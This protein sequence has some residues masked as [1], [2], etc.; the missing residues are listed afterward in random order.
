MNRPRFDAA[1]LGAGR[2]ARGQLPAALFGLSSHGRVLDWQVNALRPYCDQVTFVGGYRF[3]EI[4]ALYPS[5]TAVINPNWAATGAVGSLQRIVS[6]P[7]RSC[8]VSYADV[9]YRDDLVRQLCDHPADCVIAVD[10]RWQ[11]RYEGRSSTDRSFAE[12]LSLKAGSMLSAYGRH[13]PN[14]PAMPDAEFVGLAKLGPGALA[15]LRSWELRPG[16]DRWD[17]PQLL[18]ELTAAGHSV[19]T[20]D[21]LGDWAELNAPQDI[22]HFV[23]GTKAETL[24]RLGPMVRHSHIGEQVAFT[25]GEWQR[26]ATDC[27]L[28][29][30]S[31]F[32]NCRLIIRSSAL[33]EDGFG[34]SGAGRFES[35]L[36]VDGASDERLTH[37]VE[38]VL[39]SYADGN[40][41]HQI[42]V[43]RMVADIWLSGVMMTRTLS[44]GAPYRVIN[45]DTGSCTSDSVTSGRGDTQKTL[46]IHRD[47]DYL[48][49]D[50][51][52]ILLALMAAA[53]EIENLV[54]H[55]SLDIE[56][57]ISRDD[58]VHILQIRPIAV[59]HGHWQGSDELV[60]EAL[61]TARKDFT[62]LQT[63]GP[64]V[65]GRRAPFSVMT[66]WN[67]AEMIGTR[68]R[69]LAYSLYADLITHDVWAL[70][71]GQ[72][73]YRQVGPHALM[74]SFAGHPYIDVR[75]S[76]NSFVP[77]D[78]DSELAT[79]LVDH[80]IDDLF[81]H[82]LLHDKVEFE[83]VY[84]CLGLDFD[85]RSRAL[86]AAGFTV[87]E[88]ER[89]RVSLASLTS[90]GIARVDADR[91]QVDLLT[92]RQQAIE[93]ARLPPLRSALALLDD[94]RTHGTLPFAH[95]ARGAFVA[96]TL[97]NSAVDTDVISSD[98]RADYLKSVATITADYRIDCTLLKAGAL[99]LAEFLDR[100]GH[101]RPGTYDITA[102]S[103]AEDPMR[104]LDVAQ[105]IGPAAASAPSSLPAPWSGETRA[106]FAAALAK[107]GLCL[108]FDEADH[109]MRQA[110]GGREYAKFVFTRGLS[111]ALDHIAAFGVD[112]DLTR[113]DLSHLSL[114]DLRA[115]DSGWLCN[116]P[117]GSLRNRAEEGRLAHELTLGVELPPLL[118]DEVDFSSFLNPDA[119]AN[120]IGDRAVTASIICIEQALASPLMLAGK[121]VLARQADPGYDWLFAQGIA[122]LVT[123]YGG[124]NSHMAVRAAEFGLPAA[125]GV[126][127]QRYDRLAASSRLSL[128]CQQRTITVLH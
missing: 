45:Y 62:R 92:P 24:E 114:A 67:P 118:L 106:R 3:A 22:A 8:L 78:L 1:I 15:Q 2:P 112:S 113:E 66:D 96:M 32:G 71:R 81:A 49:L 20:V 74:H 124:A 119:V 50:A 68:P 85:R 73:G 60:R 94:C 47:N 63:P 103:Y 120:F 88:I 25:A 48:P 76:F 51:P 30:R 13:A 90:R 121:I 91:A 87:A 12:V 107:A 36:D 29:V 127:E 82:P 26:S 37:S 61:A 72:Y 70:Q 109:F 27:L 123:A 46:Y 16:M 31:V 4:V 9:L 108:S 42:L 75:A 38:R 10:S 65:Q 77:A 64:F 111:R 23:M 34:S 18:N 95:L 54:G 79:R 33:G 6:V 55:D 43:Q 17:M 52:A 86:R 57:I 21:C 101:L 117:V 40:P 97:L 104:Y 41:A 14:R 128:D 84:S 39:N 102:P 116:D 35:V 110:I 126:G 5:L 7:G 80:C 44:H 28:R 99:S 53:R 58:A 100:Y 19:A 122:G 98:E 11:R 105:H 93:G 59:D 89:L 115:V 125:I 83:I 69:R 56:F